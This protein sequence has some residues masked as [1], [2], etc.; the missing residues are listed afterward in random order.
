MWIAANA[1]PC[2]PKTRKMEGKLFRLFLLFLFRPIQPP[3][4]HLLRR[5]GDFEEPHS[6][7]H[8]RLRV[9]DLPLGLEERIC[10]GN[11]HQHHRPRRKGIHHVQIAAKPAQLAHPRGDAHVGFL[12][13]QLGARDERISR[14]TAF[15]LVFDGGLQRIPLS[16]MVRRFALISVRPPATAAF[17]LPGP[18]LPSLHSSRT[19]F[20]RVLFRKIVVISSFPR[21]PSCHPGTGGPTHVSQTHQHHRRFRFDYPSAHPWRRLFCARRAEGSRLVRRLRLHWHHGLLHPADAHPG[22]AGLPGHLRRIPRRHW[23]SPRIPRARRRPRHSLQHAGGCMDG[24]LQVR[25]FYQL[26][27]CKN[28]R[29]V[30]VSS[31]C[32]RRCPGPDDQRLR[33][34]LH[35]SRAFKI[36]SARSLRISPPV[37]A[38]LLWHRKPFRAYNP[39]RFRFEPESYMVEDKLR[40]H[41]D[42][43]LGK[44]EIV[45]YSILAVLLA[46]TA[47]VTIATA[48]QILWID[49]SHWTVAA[50]TL[51]VL[52]QLLIVLMLVEILHTVRISIR[53]HV[54][55][56][57]PNL[58]VGLI[59]SIRRILVITLEAATLTKEGAWATEGANGVF[60]SSMIELG[61]LGLLVLVLVVSITLLR[62]YAPASKD[63]PE[64]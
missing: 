41:F 45:I 19:S 46:V 5:R 23:I 12:F 16:T 21:N 10:R 56:T 4:Q 33:R 59:A 31:A 15:L 34:P 62:R 37:L 54:V 39:H 63:L 52:N 13:D 38:G 7:S 53:S 51:R 27:R 47:F 25:I 50:Q 18:I 1:F 3:F 44:T 40:R 28:G 6:R 24:A 35:R 20:L 8:I 32:H 14:R 26:V 64:L 22:A 42:Y 11:L 17:S 43:Y 36:L 30:R 57:E 49:L 61:L 55:V 58:V 29:R 9:N 60:R 48:G 2:G